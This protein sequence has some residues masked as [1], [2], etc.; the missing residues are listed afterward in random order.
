MLFHL[1][2]RLTNNFFLCFYREPVLQWSNSITK[3]LETAGEK[4]I[5]CDN[6]VVALGEEANGK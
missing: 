6:L 5:S 2:F 4:R 1:V 3:E